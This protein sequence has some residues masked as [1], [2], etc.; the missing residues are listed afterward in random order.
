M[1]GLYEQAMWPE[2]FTILKRRLRPFSFGHYIIL[3]RFNVC[4][5]NDDEK[6]LTIEDLVFSVYVCSHSYKEC[7]TL[8]YSGKWFDEVY[9]W[10][11]E[12]STEPSLEQAADEFRRYL[13]HHTIY[14]LFKNLNNDRSTSK[15][16]GEIYEKIISTVASKQ[17]YKR[18]DVLELNYARVMYEYLS[19]M[20]QQGAISFYSKQDFINLEKFKAS[21]MT[22]VEQEKTTNG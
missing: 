6:P 3:K 5:A 10:S 16:N 2:P 14:P 22:I 15:S 19:Y 13:D 12:F 1:N 8:F 7:E 18:D 17:N 11:K 9:E 20:E 21:M 4:Y